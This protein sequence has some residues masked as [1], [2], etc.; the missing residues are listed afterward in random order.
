MYLAREVARSYGC[1]KGVDR[2]FVHQLIV[3]YRVTVVA[4]ALAHMYQSDKNKG[5]H[6]MLSL[7]PC[8]PVPASSSR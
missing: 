3:Y 4:N 1:L 7:D 6:I 2:A 5:T 8:I